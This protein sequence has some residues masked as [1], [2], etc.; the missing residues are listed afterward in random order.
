MRNADGDGDSDAEAAGDGNG[1]GVPVS[2]PVTGPPTRLTLQS[3]SIEILAYAS[4][5]T[6]RHYKNIP[7]L[8][9]PSG[10]PAYEEAFTNA[11]RKENTWEVLNGEK[12]EPLPL[13][14]DAPID[15]WNEYIRQLAIYRRRNNVLLGALRSTLAP[16]LATSLGVHYYACA[17]WL[18]LKN[19]C[20]PSTNVEAWGRF[21][22]LSSTTLASCENDFHRY[23]QTMEMRWHEFNRRLPPP[24]A[25]GWQ[26]CRFT[27]ELFCL[28]FLEN[29]GEENRRRLENV[30]QGFNIGGYGAG[31]RIGFQALVGVVAPLFRRGH[32]EAEGRV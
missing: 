26:N 11:S 12:S 25:P 15:E 16:A 23:A 5:G 9:D 17:L 31:E 3:S 18:A 30:C 13:P 19:T 20:M 7:Q 4:C 1:G 6:G 10:W 29:L 21:H 27:E 32:A 2:A 22:E 8:N 14:H 24:S 28:L